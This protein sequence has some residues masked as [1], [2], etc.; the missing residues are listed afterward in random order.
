[1]PKRKHK[2]I[3]PQ[4]FTQSAE[5]HLHDLSQTTSLDTHLVLS[6]RLKRKKQ[7]TFFYSV[8]VLDFKKKYD[9]EELAQA[10]IPQMDE[11]ELSFELRESGFWM[12][13]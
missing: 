13:M 2:M 6:L 12:P 7:E 10:V 9:D 1:M 8:V 4:I 5:Q 3:P 11:L